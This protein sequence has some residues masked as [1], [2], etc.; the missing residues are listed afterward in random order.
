MP[1]AASNPSA[2][3]IV[4]VDGGSTGIS[5]AARL[6]KSG[7]SFRIPF[8]NPSETH[9]YQPIWTLVG[10]GVLPREEAR[11]READLIPVGVDWM[12]E[13]VAKVDCDR[14]PRESFPCD[15]SKE[16]RSKC[17]LKRQTLPMLHWRGMLKGRL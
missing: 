2:R 1:N 17:V 11:R 8:V 10:V 6:R 15:Q 5:V 4:I 14:R 7:A 13:A 9:G 12:R 16:R 3:S